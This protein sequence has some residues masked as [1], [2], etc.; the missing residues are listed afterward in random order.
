MECVLLVG[1]LWLMALLWMDKAARCPSHLGTWWTPRKLSVEETRSP[2]LV[3]TLYGN[4]LCCPTYGYTRLWGRACW[5]LVYYRWW[6][7]CHVTQHISNQLLQSGA[8]AVHKIRIVVRFL[9]GSLHEFPGAS[10]VPW[11][12]TCFSFTNRFATV[13]LCLSSGWAFTHQWLL[14]Q[15]MLRYAFLL[16]FTTSTLL[17]NRKTASNLLNSMS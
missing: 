2:C 10:S 7:A 11:T 15:N 17:K 8:E 13:S 14:T 1:Q 12:C 3:S 5:V 6:V 16:T 9:L 4:K